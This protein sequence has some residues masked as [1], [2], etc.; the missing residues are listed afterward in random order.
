PVP[1]GSRALYY[2]LALT[3][4]FTLLVGTTVR[5]RR[6]HDAATLHFFWL[7]VAFFG[8]LAFSF[9]GRL[10]T[11]DRV[12]YWGDVIAMCLLPPL[13]VHFA[14]VFPDRPNA[15]VQSE[16][17]G[18]LLPLLYLPAALLGAARVALVASGGSGEAFSTLMGR[19]DTI[20]VAHLGVALVAGLAIMIRTLQRLRSVSARGQMRWGVGGTAL[21][22]LPFVAGYALPYALGSETIVGVEF[23]APLLGLLPL[24]FASAIVRWRLMDVAVIIKRRRAYAAGLAA[25]AVIY[26]ILLQVA[27]DVFL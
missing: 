17:G 14:L 3:G 19:L 20:E 22:A 26:G 16:Q 24:A 25:V 8:V 27:T 6:P 23:T 12:F 2:V 13:F 4:I 15:W 11:L 18:R 7:T 21:G 9:S 1:Q 10:D 5:L